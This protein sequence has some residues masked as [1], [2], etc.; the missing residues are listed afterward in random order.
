MLEHAE[1]LGYSHIISWSPDGMSFKIHKDGTQCKEDEK[2]IVMVLKQSFNQTR[3]KSFLRQLQLYR[4]ERTFKG[5]HRG[6]CKHPMLIRGQRD[7]LHRKSIEDF[8][9]AAM[10][11]SGA[12]ATINQVTCSPNSALNV[13][14]SSVEKGKTLNTSSSSSPPLEPESNVDSNSNYWMPSSCQAASLI[15]GLAD[16][17]NNSE[18]GNSRYRYH[19]GVG[20]SN[21]P[22]SL[23]NIFLT[24]NIS[25]K[26]DDFESEFEYKG[27]NDQCTSCNNTS[28]AIDWSSFDT[29]LEE[30]KNRH[31]QINDVCTGIIY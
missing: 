26:S 8:L 23:G 6:E 13:S 14:I 27:T 15:T 11:S 7:L 21:I 5:D 22:T 25:S 10:I 16:N 31:Q 3:F 30:P 19:G 28:V 4:F 29:E 20:T 17:N 2:A 1:E 24:D 18:S 9:D 12:T